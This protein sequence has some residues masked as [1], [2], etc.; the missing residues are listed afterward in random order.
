MCAGAKTFYNDFAPRIGFAWSP[1]TSGKVAIRGGYS[2]IYG[3]LYYADFGNSMNAGYAAS[4]NPSSAN[5]FTPAVHS[6]QCL[7]GVP[8][9]ANLDPTIR[10]N[11]SVD[12][13]SPGFGKPPMIQSW[14]FQ[15]QQQLAPGSHPQSE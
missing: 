5:G 3:P 9:R 2:I 7:P 1:G 15:V 13:I 14:S 4:P 12:Y 11:S 10:N 6:G 8:A